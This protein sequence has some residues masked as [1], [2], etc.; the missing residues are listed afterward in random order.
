MNEILPDARS[1]N[2]AERGSALVYILIAI[3][4]L[5]AL[6][7]TFMEPASQQ[8][9]SQNTFKT[10]SG[11]DSQIHLIRSSIQQCVLTYP[12]GDN[13][14]NASSTTDSGADDVYPINPDSSHFS[15]ASPGQSGNRFVRNLR[16]PGHNTTGNEED[17]VKIFSGQSG[18]F[19]PPAPPLFTDWQYY[20][21]DDGIFFWLE[22]EKSDLYI[23]SALEKIDDKY[24]E[25]EADVIDASSGAEN[26]D[27]GGDV[28]CSSGSTCFRL[29]MIANGTAVYN[30]DSDND[31][32]SC[33]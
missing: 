6:T 12:R 24:S 13:T 1:D 3:A 2:K 23:R 26:L 8:T 11:L 17:H 28:S 25:C 9:S 14:I 4:L 18:R 29:F 10:I 22:T 32:A 5:A 21:G 20:N 27:S 30:G 16:C 19:L 31:E 33:P 7:F 15:S